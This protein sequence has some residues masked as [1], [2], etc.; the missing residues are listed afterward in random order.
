MLR[1]KPR[2]SKQPL[3]TYF[4]IPT[5]YL[6]YVE[7]DSHKQPHI[8]VTVSPIRQLEQHSCN[9]KRLDLELQVNFRYHFSEQVKVHQQNED[10]ETK[11]QPV[12]FV[13]FS[14]IPTIFQ[15]AKIL[16]KFYRYLN[17]QNYY[18]IPNYSF[19]GFFYLYFRLLNN[20]E[21][22]DSRSRGRPI[23][24]LF[25]HL[26]PLCAYLDFSWVITAG[27]SPL[28]KAIYRTRLGPHGFRVRIPNH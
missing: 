16:I 10:Q 6:T 21:S 22:Q 28:R 11:F 24:I 1:T 17:S 14:L 7:R 19:L 18:L 25:Y 23:L 13:Y 4:I 2:G 3:Q 9:L 8:K 15:R 26:H 12:R 20:H 5:I 27:S